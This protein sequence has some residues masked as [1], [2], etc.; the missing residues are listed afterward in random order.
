MRLIDADAVI[1]RYYA[2]WEYHCIKMEKDEREWL[3][4]CIEQADTVDAVAL[5]CKPGQTIYRVKNRE[6]T[7]SAYTAEGFLYDGAFWKVRAT[8]MVPLWIGNQKKHWYISFSSFGKTVFLTR[9]EAEAALAER[10]S[11]D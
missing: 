6:K 4:Q 1:S 8:E 5:P 7:I 3:K 10:R 2:E 11:D 9:A